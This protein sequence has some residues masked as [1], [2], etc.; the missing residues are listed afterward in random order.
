M[1][2]KMFLSGS[3]MPSFGG[4][5]GVLGFAAWSPPIKKKES[6]CDHRKPVVAC[7][8]PPL[9]HRAATSSTKEKLAQAMAEAAEHKSLAG[10]HRREAKALR[11]MMQRLQSHMP[12]KAP[13]NSL[14]IEEKDQRKQPAAKFEEKLELGL[15]IHQMMKKDHLSSDSQE[16]ATVAFDPDEAFSPMC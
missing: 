2:E 7:S 3:A 13:V 10:S 14:N 5:S 11:E 4:A 15:S 6:S 8:F 16:Q 9:P 1:F 12:C